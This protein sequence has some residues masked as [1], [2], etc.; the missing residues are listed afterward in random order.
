[1]AVAATTMDDGQSS[2]S[3]VTPIDWAGAGDCLDQLGLVRTAAQ[4]G[5]LDKAHAPPFAV[6]LVTPT[7]SLDWVSAPTV[8]LVADMPLESYEDQGAAAAAAPCLL[9]V[10]Q[11][12]DLR[13]A[14]R[15]IDFQNVASLYQTGVRTERNPDYDAAQA[16][17]KEAQRESK[18]RGLGVLQVG[19]PLLDLIGMLVG[20]VIATFDQFDSD[21]DLDEKLAALKDTP[22]SQD[23]PV[24]RAYEFERS[25][26][27]AGKEAT[28]PIALRDVKRDRIWRAQLRQREMRQFS[29]VEGLDPRDRDYEQHRAGA[30]SWEEFDH[31]QGEP[32]QLPISALIAALVDSGTND[33]LPQTGGPELIADITP[34]TGPTDPSAAD[35]VAQP[36][37]TTIEPEAG[38]GA[39]APLALDGSSDAPALPWPDPVPSGRHGARAEPTVFAAAL[40]PRTASLVRLETGSHRGSGFYVRPRLVA[41]TADLVGTA[42]MVDVT[43][44]DGEKVLGLVVH[45]DPARNLAV[46]HVPRTGRPA[47]LSQRLA[48]APGQAV[49]VLELLGHDRARMT[50]A[51]LQPAAAGGSAGGDE[52]LE[53]DLAGAPATSGAPVFINDRAVGLIADQDG[54]SRRRI[55]PT[56]ALAA[57]LASEPLA[58]LR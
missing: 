5:R 33:G 13:A 10:E 45:T 51:A 25:T 11:P 55:M 42:S 18:R 41:T 6:V 8:P 2:A 1:M 15:V 39:S 34:G 54:G 7:T 3:P 47:V 27:R 40:D 26:V 21:G 58:A 49:D 32:P 20:G 17:L 24:Y 29:V 31:W 48:L 30:F 16:R 57:I 22:R 37:L 9:L 23:R 44:S 53:L 43:T 4:S 28:V 14:H 56:D 35:G 36:L 46:M 38:P 19:D 12:S 52:Q 50:I